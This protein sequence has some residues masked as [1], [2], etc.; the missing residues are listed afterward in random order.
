MFL[1][2]SLSEDGLQQRLIPRSFHTTRPTIMGT[3]TTTTTTTIADTVTVT[4]SGFLGL[5][6]I[7]VD[8]GMSA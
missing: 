2:S 7:V 5:H 1:C 6:M 8:V 3:T 4:T